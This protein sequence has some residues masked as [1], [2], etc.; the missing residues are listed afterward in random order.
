MGI[1]LLIAIMMIS[2]AANAAPIGIA[3]IVNDDVITSLDVKERRDL[4]DQKPDR[5]GDSVGE[6]WRVGVGEGG[7]TTS[8]SHGVDTRRRSAK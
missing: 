2:S 4:A 5:R 7:E 8:G 1:R 3:A 6:L